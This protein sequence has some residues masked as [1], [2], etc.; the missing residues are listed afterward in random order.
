MP[1]VRQYHT[2][3]RI[4]RGTERR[5]CFVE[6]VMIMMGGKAARSRYTLP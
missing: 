1:E 3:Q 2:S 4:P 5:T 6:A